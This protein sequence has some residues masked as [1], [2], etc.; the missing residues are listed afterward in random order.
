MNHDN[1]HKRNDTNA[2]LVTQDSKYAD[3]HK[4]GITNAPGRSHYNDV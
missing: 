3:A 4:V 2:M 1:S